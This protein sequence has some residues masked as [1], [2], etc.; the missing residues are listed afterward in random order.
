MDESSY[1]NLSI[2]VSTEAGK[3]QRSTSEWGPD[4]LS[5][6]HF[7]GRLYSITLHERW[8][9]CYSLLP[10]VKINMAA[11][12]MT[13]A[14]DWVSV[15]HLD[16][17]NIN[18]QPGLWGNSGISFIANGAP[19]GEANK[20]GSSKEDRSW[21]HNKL[22]YFQASCQRCALRT[23]CVHSFHHPDEGT[24][25]MDPTETIALPLHYAQSG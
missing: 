24:G 10:T 18:Q 9:I 19:S 23:V 12:M 1:G 11:Q 2:Q 5:G 13:G 22:D 14:S 7:S 20:E 25:K 8:E 15:E 16:Y 21:K 3:T 4:G 6:C 17:K